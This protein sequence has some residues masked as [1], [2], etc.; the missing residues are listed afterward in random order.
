MFLLWNALGENERWVIPCFRALGISRQCFRSVAEAN[1]SCL[2]HCAHTGVRAVL[3]LWIPPCRVTAQQLGLL[4][5]GEEPNLKPTE[6]RDL[7]SSPDMN[8]SQTFVTF[9]SNQ[10]RN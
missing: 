1:P 8:Q 7:L 10:L 4:T 6:K 3:L 5:Q 9:Q 2:E